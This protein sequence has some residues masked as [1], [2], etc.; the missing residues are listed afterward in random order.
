MVI[1][2]MLSPK[3]FPRR[4]ILY[5]NRKRGNTARQYEAKCSRSKAETRNVSSRNAKLSTEEM[6][7][8]RSNVTSWRMSM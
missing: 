7:D 2:N 1:S 6:V 4:K 3:V 5:D 8:E